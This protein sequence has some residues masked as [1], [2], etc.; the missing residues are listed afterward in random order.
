M[1]KAKFIY[2]LVTKIIHVIQLSVF[3]NIFSY[4]EIFTL[5][6]IYKKTGKTTIFKRLIV[7]YGQGISEKS[8][9]NYVDSIHS[10]VIE[11]I[12]MLVRKSDEIS[13]DWDS[14]LVKLYKSLIY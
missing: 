10:N 4:S 1:R 2:L 14:F 8:R 13:N 12:Q 5:F 9:L 7:D 3:I 6:L 11:S